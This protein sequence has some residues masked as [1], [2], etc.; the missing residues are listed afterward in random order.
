MEGGKFMYVYIILDIILIK[1]IFNI[2]NILFTYII[3]YIIYIMI[4]IFLLCRTRR[5]H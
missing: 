3:I 5:D 1:R 4:A 2:K